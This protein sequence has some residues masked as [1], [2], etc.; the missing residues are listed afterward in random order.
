MFLNVLCGKEDYNGRSIDNAGTSFDDGANVTSQRFYDWFVLCVVSAAID[1]ITQELARGPTK[2]QSIGLRSRLA[3]WT[4]TYRGV[5]SSY[6]SWKKYLKS[7]SCL[8]ILKK[9]D[10]LR[11]SQSQ[12]KQTVGKGKTVMIMIKDV[13]NYTCRT[14]IK[15]L[16]KNTCEQKLG[17]KKYTRNNLHKAMNAN[18]I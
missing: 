1:R 11:F 3:C 4:V 2:Y 9:C 17:I 13:Q 15:V 10:L 14:A 6:L 18:S 12:I 8:S 5:N 7:L 16:R